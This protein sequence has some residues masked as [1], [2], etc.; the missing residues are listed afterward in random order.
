MVNFLIDKVVVLWCGLID[1]WVKML[2]SFSKIFYSTYGHWADYL[3]NEERTIWW[4]SKFATQDKGKGGGSGL[5]VKKLLKS[6]S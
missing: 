3:G 6:I 5:G 2:N 1:D 4:P